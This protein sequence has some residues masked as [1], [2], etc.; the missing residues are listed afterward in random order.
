M[1]LAPFLSCAPDRGEP[2]LRY[3]FILRYCIRTNVI[4]YAQGKTPC[5]AVASCA[6]ADQSLVRGQDP[7]SIRTLA[8]TG[9][10]ALLGI[11]ARPL[12]PS[13]VQRYLPA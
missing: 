1:S 10:A 4:A 11:A 3:R 7:C 13:Y 12:N 2:D 8:G 5:L 6:S 9:P